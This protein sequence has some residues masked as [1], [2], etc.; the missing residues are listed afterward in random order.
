LLKPGTGRT[1][2][3]LS[4]GT[5]TNSSLQGVCDWIL[6]HDQILTVVSL[7]QA[8]FFHFG[9]AVKAS[10]VFLRKRAFDE[11][12]SDDEAVFMAV[13]ENIGYDSTG[14]KSYEI[15]LEEEKDDELIERHE[16][17][18]FHWRVRK[19]WSEDENGKG[20]WW[21]RHREIIPNTGLIGR[22]GAFREDPEPF[23]V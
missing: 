7:P 11:V 19:I 3:V 13:A 5:L 22:Y 12:L 9:A 15:I 16:C 1:A 10:L 20:D 4:D 17:D 8:A 2:I 18:L 14:K 23:F 21:E 6:E